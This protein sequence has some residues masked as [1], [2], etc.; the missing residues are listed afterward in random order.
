MLRDICTTTMLAKSVPSYLKTAK[1]ANE[2][3]RY[4]LGLEL[5]LCVSYMVVKIQ[6][7]RPYTSD[8][9]SSDH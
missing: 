4:L 3:C 6:D 8:C 9:V 2:A 1:G 5:P 7:D